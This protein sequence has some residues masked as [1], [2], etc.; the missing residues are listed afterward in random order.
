MEAPPSWPS[1]VEPLGLRPIRGHGLR[2]VGRG[3][4]K[5]RTGLGF[6]GRRLMWGGGAL[7]CWASPSRKGDPLPQSANLRIFPPSNTTQ[8]TSVSR[9]PEGVDNQGSFL[10]IFTFLPWPQTWWDASPSVLQLHC[11]G[12]LI[13]AG[14]GTGAVV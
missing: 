3:R 9:Q 13:A 6:M 4:Q 10:F 5:S 11:N 14:E 7:V 12:S 2:A 1:K 8:V